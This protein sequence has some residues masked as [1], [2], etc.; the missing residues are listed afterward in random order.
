MINRRKYVKKLKILTK[1]DFTWSYGNIDP[2]GQI[3][4]YKNVISNIFYI[5]EQWKYI[6]VKKDSKYNTIVS[7]YNGTS[8]IQKSIVTAYDSKISLP[9]NVTAIRILL[10]DKPTTDYVQRDS[11]FKVTLY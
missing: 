6:K 1:E 5:G 7:A 8:F 10:W 4:T 9:S 3:T 2:N 11:T